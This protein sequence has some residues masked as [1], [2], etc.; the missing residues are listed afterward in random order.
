MQLANYNFA[1]YRPEKS[2]FLMIPSRKK[3]G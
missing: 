2:A 3:V 1:A